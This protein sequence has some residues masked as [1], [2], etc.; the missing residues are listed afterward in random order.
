MIDPTSIR[1]I[2]IAPWSPG[3]TE[4]DDGADLTAIAHLI[5]ELGYPT[6]AAT[7]R[8]RLARMMRVRAIMPMDLLVARDGETIVGL[9][10]VASLDLALDVGTTAELRAL[11][12]LS[13]RRGEGIGEQLVLAAQDWARAH[14]AKSLTLRTSERRIDAHRFYERLGF[15]QVTTART[16]TMPL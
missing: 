6:D 5:T 14:G 11:V 13:T 15:S 16:Y 4:D 8:D 10:M 7:Q 3:T 12:V 9:A 2:R 1:S